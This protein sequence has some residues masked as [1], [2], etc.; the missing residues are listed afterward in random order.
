MWGDEGS[1]DLHIKLYL[2]IMAVSCFNCDY[3]LNILEEQF[4]LNGG[5]IEWLTHGLKAVDVRVLKFA[6]IN[7]ILAYQPWKLSSKHV[8][9][10]LKS[11]D[12]PGW[13]F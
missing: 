1:L 12:G 5:S 9:Q 8:E 7:E 13:S 6:E 4:V 3:M 2:G 10:L 11:Q